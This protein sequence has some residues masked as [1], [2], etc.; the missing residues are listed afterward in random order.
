MRAWRE[1]LH[2]RDA[3]GLGERIVADFGDGIVLNP[4]RLLNYC[5]MWDLA[6]RG[7]AGWSDGTWAMWIKERIRDLGGFRCDGEE[8]ADH[9]VGVFHMGFVGVIETP[10][11]LA[12]L[13]N[14]HLLA[15]ARVARSKLGATHMK[16][17]PINRVAARV[18][19]L[20]GPREED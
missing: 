5:C 18:A 10:E 20:P 1:L 19:P 9:V 6:D 8:L 4:E 16:I 17:A 7:M 14:E 13:R 12:R 2:D 3:E 15:R 11:H